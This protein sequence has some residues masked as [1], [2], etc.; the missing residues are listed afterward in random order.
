MN[1][2]NQTIYFI[3]F[4]G[5]LGSGVLEYG[6]VTLVGGAVTETKTRL[7]AATGRV[8]P[9]DVD[10]HGLSAEAVAGHR[11]LAEDWDLFADLR[12]RGP[13]AAHYAGAENALLKSVWAYPRSSPDFARPGE[14]VI[15]WGPWIDSAR[16]YGQLYPDLESGRLE[17]VVAACGLQGELDRLAADHCPPARRR[18]HAALY[19]A[20]A[21]ALLLVSLARQ[22]QL[23]GLTVTQ[24]L[25]LSTLDPAKRE[26]IVQ[27]NL[28]GGPNQAAGK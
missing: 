23:A 9:G 12:E 25:A 7:C 17:S 28:F 15:D 4:E 1:W 3:D 19:D 10:I 26:S 18:Y 2:T 5:S 21:G 24:L 16:L 27:M 20:I 22:P 13:F 8:R 6:I 11:P 14:R